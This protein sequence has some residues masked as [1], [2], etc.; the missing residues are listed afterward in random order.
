LRRRSLIHPSEG[1]LVKKIGWHSSVERIEL[2]PD[3]LLEGEDA[4]HE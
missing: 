4:L 1:I 2:A 3:P